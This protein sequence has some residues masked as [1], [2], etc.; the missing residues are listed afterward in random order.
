MTNFLTSPLHFQVPGNLLL[1][2]EYAVLEEG[3]L[4]IC[5]PTSASCVE[6]TVQRAPALTLTGQMATDTIEWKTWGDATYFDLALNALTCALEYPLPT[7]PLHIT[8]DSRAFFTKTGKKT[9]FGSSAAV[10]AG[11]VL[12]LQIALQRPASVLVQAAISAHRALQEGQGSGY[13]V[14]TSFYGKPSLFTGG[15][16]PI[17]QDIPLILL[18]CFTLHQGQSSV[19]SRDA[20][21]QF[22]RTKTDN[23][24]TIAR[25]VAHSNHLIQGI[26]QTHTWPKL[27][28]LWQEAAH[29]SQ[30]LGDLIEVPAHP[31]EGLTNCDAVVK[32]LGA[33]NELTGIF[34]NPYLIDQGV[35]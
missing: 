12:A 32:C 14:M 34:S 1:V 8:L 31:P 29:L 4:G 16:I 18:P 26:L 20:I 27:R 25:Y 15:Q 35:A 17:W 2:G 6:V 13:D 7:L 28:T 11:L 3:G 24:H 9:G 19:S 30:A 5:I 10:I 22:L 23:P 21:K 33:G